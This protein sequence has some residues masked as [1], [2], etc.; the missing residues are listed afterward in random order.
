MRIDNSRTFTPGAVFS[1]SSGSK[2]ET[3]IPRSTD[4][5]L[6]PEP[7]AIAARRF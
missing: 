2:I 5:A 7:S 3:F 4:D 1:S 6:D